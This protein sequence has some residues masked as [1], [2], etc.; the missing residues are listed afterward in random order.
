M[1]PR[2]REKVQV[3]VC[4]DIDGIG[5]LLSHEVISVWFKNVLKTFLGISAPSSSLKDQASTGSHNS[6]AEKSE[7]SEMPEII[8]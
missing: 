7:G 4:L 1:P 3:S 5:L 2:L 8:L 6:D